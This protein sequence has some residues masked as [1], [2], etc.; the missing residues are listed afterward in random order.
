MQHREWS[1]SANN[2]CEQLQQSGDLF[3]GLVGTGEQ[4]RRDGDSNR[5]SRL[6][7]DHQLKA[8]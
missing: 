2:G 4:R 1:K 7:I 3:D 8:G 6:Q 5:F